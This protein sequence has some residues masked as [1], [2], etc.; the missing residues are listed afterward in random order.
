M[1]HNFGVFDATYESRGTVRGLSLLGQGLSFVEVRGG[2]QLSSTITSSGRDFLRCAS[3]C[4]GINCLVEF[5]NYVDQLKGNPQP[6]LT[7]NFAEGPCPLL[8]GP[9]NATLPPFPVNP[10]PNPADAQNG[11]PVVFW[12]S[13]LGSADNSVVNGTIP[14]SVDTNWLQRLSCVR[15]TRLLFGYHPQ[16]LRILRAGSV[17]HNSKADFELRFAVGF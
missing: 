7:S 15:D 17:A 5:A 9:Q 6:Y 12:P 8:L 1:G 3:F 2:S 11:V 4:P 16:L 13:P 10:G 14:P